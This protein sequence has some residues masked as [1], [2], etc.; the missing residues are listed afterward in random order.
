MTKFGQGNIRAAKKTP[1]EIL[2]IRQKYAEG[3][4]QGR[5]ARYSGLSVGQIGR[6]VRNEV[7]QQYAEVPT[8][9]E[10]GHRIA[11]APAPIAAE[12]EAS[13]ISLLAK[14]NAPQSAPAVDPLEEIMQ[15]RSMR[16]CA[17]CK[18]SIPAVD[19]TI[20]GQPAHMQCAE[21]AGDI[22]TAAVPQEN[23]DETTNS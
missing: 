22:E 15:R 8:E 13:E 20:N 2:D 9:Q 14:L 21:A 1:D 10:I 12:V 7:W 23:D 3:W 16:V 19:C 11:T 18:L 4:S 5:L 6:I 17:Y